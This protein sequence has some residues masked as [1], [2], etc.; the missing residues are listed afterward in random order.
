MS[1]LAFW[2]V[3]VRFWSQLWS[4]MA[5]GRRF[6]RDSIWISWVDS[7]RPSG[8]QDELLFVSPGFVRRRGL[9]P[10]L[11]SLGPSGTKA[12]SVQLSGRLLSQRGPFLAHLD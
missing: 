5:A 9:H 12:V 8:A 10:G 1:A 6:S 7:R 3:E 2:T 4:S 11:F